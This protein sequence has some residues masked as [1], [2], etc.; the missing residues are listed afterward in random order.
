MGG[1]PVN[2]LLSDSGSDPCANGIVVVITRD[3]VQIKYCSTNAVIA[4][5]TVIQLF[6]DK[7][8]N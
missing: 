7:R 5:V 3:S 4:S 2:V 1:D 6:K 8:N